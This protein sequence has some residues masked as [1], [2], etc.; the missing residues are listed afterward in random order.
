M[1]PTSADEQE[2]ARPRPGLPMRIITAAVKGQEVEEV[3]VR[4]RSNYGILPLIFY[5]IFKPRI[6]FCAK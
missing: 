2:L 4:M 5:A 1:R 3:E 6:F